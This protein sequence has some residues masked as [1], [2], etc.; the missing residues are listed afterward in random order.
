MLENSGCYSDV[1]ATAGTLTITQKPLTITAGSDSKEY[2]GNA[3]TKNDYGITSGELVSGESISSITITGSQTRVGSSDNVPS[4]AVIKNANNDIVTGNY[5]ITY[6]KGTLTVTQSTKALVITSATKS[7][8]YDGNTHKDETYTVTLGGVSALVDATG[9]VFTLSTGDVLTITPTAAGV[10]DYSADYSENNTYT[11]VLA[12]AD[13]YSS[14]TANIGTLSINKNTSPLV[15]TSATNSWTYDGNTHKDETYTVTFGGATVSPDATADANGKV[16]TLS[17]GD[18]LTIT[19]TA[20]GVKDYSANYSENN[21]YTYELV[22]AGCYSSVTANT[23]TLSI[24]KKDATITAQSKVFLYTGATQSWNKYDVEGLEGSDAISAVVSGSIT[25]PSEGPVTN[26]VESYEFTSGNPNN[27]SVTT[28][29]GEL[30]IT[31][32][33]YV[34]LVCPLPPL[35]IL[36]VYFGHAAK[37]SVSSR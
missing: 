34:H 30:T 17:T 24:N 8:T 2:D 15:I 25:L 7:W 23:G 14:K 20:A 21:T 37:N 36:A 1:T 19:P 10:K 29:D 11:Y 9:K 32:D 31:R 3:L 33:G 12:N 18:V 6:N 28:F 35:C 4:A 16:F 5:D 22:N 13:Y 27:Y 26:R